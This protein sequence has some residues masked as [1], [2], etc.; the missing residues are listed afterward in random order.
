M[1]DE[2]FVGTLPRHALRE[3]VD[4]ALAEDL[5]SGDLTTECC[6]DPAVSAVARAVARHPLVVCGGDVFACVFKQVDPLCAVEHAHPDG[7][8]VVADAVVWEVRGP[9]QSLLSAERVALNFT[10]RM[11]GIATLARRYQEAVTTGTKTRITDTR[12]TT[13]GLR[14]LERYAV[15]VGGASNHRDNL[16]SAILIKDNHIIAAGSI[17]AAVARAQA[18][19]P[20]SSRIEVEVNTLAELEQAQRAGADIIMLDNMDTPMVVEAL[21]RIDELTG[22]GQR[23]IVEASGGIT[24]ERIAE[25]SAAGVDVISTGALTHSVPAADISLELSFDD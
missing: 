10:A 25:L 23:P 24:L 20:H 12:K 21:E 17:A 19:A 13:P 5:G 1:S 16:G 6:V 14:L 3:L 9:A 2:L 11:C 8:Q 4:R 7:D 15:R 18:R 22:G